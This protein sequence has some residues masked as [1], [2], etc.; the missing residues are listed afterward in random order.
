MSADPVKVTS[1]DLPGRC[2]SCG[3]YIF[4]TDT[5]N[6]HQAATNCDAE[7]VIPGLEGGVQ[8]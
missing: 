1:S 5:W 7:R 2:A 8:S 4:R 3:M 6:G